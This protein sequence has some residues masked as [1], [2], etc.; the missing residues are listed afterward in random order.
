SMIISTGCVAQT[1]PPLFQTAYN[2]LSA[3]SKNF[4]DAFS[5]IYNQAALSS[6][7]SITAGLYTEKRFLLK[8]LDFYAFTASLPVMA[9]AMGFQADYFGF[10]DYNQSKLGIA[11]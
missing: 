3:Y 11:Y 8:E 10:A 6:Q 7:Q 1:I 4:K 5:F 2:S 9:G